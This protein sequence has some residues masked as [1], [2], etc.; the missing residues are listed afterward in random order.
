MLGSWGLKYGPSS[1]LFING[2]AYRWA[3]LE[4]EGR[5]QELRSCPAFARR[6]ALGNLAVLELIAPQTA[7]EI[8]EI[9]QVKA[10]PN[11]VRKGDR[12]EL[13][14]R[15]PRGR[16]AYF[17]ITGV[18]PEI[19]AAETAP[20]VYTAIYKVPEADV[21]A[22]RVIGVWKDGEREC[23]RVGTA[24]DISSREPNLVEYGP[25]QRTDGEEVL[26]FAGY[27]AWGTEVVPQLVRVWIGERE[28][29]HRAVCTERNMVCRLLPQ[30]IGQRPL[31]CIKITDRCGASAKVYWR[32]DN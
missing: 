31:F 17:V 28:I 18:A 13:Q 11:C 19:E 27:R 32:W 14:M 16:R 4:K 1:A 5:L 22:A 2:R 8:G 24:V 3:D 30:E 20:G 12:L 26:L 9:W 25:L 21:K 10:S 6:D 7:D 15:A 29:T 23:R